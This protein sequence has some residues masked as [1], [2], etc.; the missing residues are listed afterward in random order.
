[1]FRS[2]TTPVPPAELIRR[3]TGSSETDAFEL[4]GPMHIGAFERALSLAGKTYDD[5]TSIYDFGCGCGRLT[6]PLRERVPGAW[7]AASDIDGDATGWLAEHAP[8][9]DVR[10]ND[11]LPPLPWPSATFDLVVGWSVFTHLPEDYQ[12]AWLAELRRVTTPGGILCL[13]IHGRSNWRWTW[14]EPLRHLRFS[15]VRARLSW[16]RARR[17]FVHWRED[18]WSQE[19]WNTLFPGYYHTTWHRLGYIRAHWSR[20]LD[21]VAIAPGEGAEHDIVVLRRPIRP[22]RAVPAS[23]GSM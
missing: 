1:M 10:T 9:V 15:R 12:D 2:V 3:V 23:R 19:G 16:E 20:W 6:L 5:F 21:V 17:G 7:I 14:D 18:G 4:T 13:S 22:E 8:D 11:W